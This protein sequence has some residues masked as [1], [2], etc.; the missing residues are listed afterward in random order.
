MSIKKRMRDAQALAEKEL[1]RRPL[2]LIVTPRICAHARL[3]L[4]TRDGRQQREVVFAST[5]SCPR[6]MDHLRKDLRRVLR[7]FEPA[8][9][10]ARP[11]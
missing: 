10:G 1:A 4:S 7:Q 6:W 11:A 5:P 9:P 3:V 8:T 2:D